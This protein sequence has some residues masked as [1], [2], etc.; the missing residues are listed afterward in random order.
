MLDQ[1]G[2]IMINWIKSEPAKN[3]IS[4]IS[5]FYISR[6]VVVLQLWKTF[7]FQEKIGFHREKLWYVTKEV[8]LDLAKMVMG[9][10]DH[11]GYDGIWSC[12]MGQ[13]PWNS[14]VNPEM[15]GIYECSSPRYGVH[16]GIDDKWFTKSGWW[17]Q[18]LWKMS[19]SWDYYSQYM[20]SHK[21]HVPNHQPEMVHHMG[22]HQPVMVQ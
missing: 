11:H 13:N 7:G 4:G 10:H 19:V 15:A 21:I 20:E 16:Q 6:S 1:F 5:M 9:T 14:V 3:Y 2:S 22:N 18:P 17:F 8:V 12:A